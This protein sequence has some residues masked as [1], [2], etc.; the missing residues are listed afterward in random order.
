MRGQEV[1]ITPEAI[2]SLYWAEPIQP[3]S[4]FRRK[5]DDKANQFQ[6]VANTIA[7][8]Q[9]QWVISRGLIHRRDV[10]FEAR[11]WLDLASCPL[12][13]PLDKTVWDNSVITLAT[14]TDRD[15]PAMKR[16]KSIENRT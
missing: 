1:P 3:N 16:A 2:N 4:T 14:K 13:W 11:M 7:M 10:K 5:V 8:G 15:A 6:R 9:P 12:F